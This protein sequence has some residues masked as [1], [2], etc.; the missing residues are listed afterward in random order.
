MRLGISIVAVSTTMVMGIESHRALG[1][2]VGWVI[3]RPSGGRR[4][5]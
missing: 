1:G 4:A 2:R 3:A 5:G